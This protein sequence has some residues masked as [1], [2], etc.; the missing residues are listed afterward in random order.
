MSTQPSPRHALILAASWFGDFL[1]SRR[2]LG[3]SGLRG[4]RRNLHAA[5]EIRTHTIATLLCSQPARGLVTAGTPFLPKSISPELI[6]LTRRM[7]E[8]N[9][10]RANINRDYNDFVARVALQVVN[11]W[12][13]KHQRG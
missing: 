9:L 5:N 7:A 1:G 3:A 11:G 10:F 12:W 6:P 2:T 4:I 8:L 13:W